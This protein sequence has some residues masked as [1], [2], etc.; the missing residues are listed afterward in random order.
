MCKNNSTD[1]LM[2]KLAKR[3]PFINER[4]NLYESKHLDISISSVV[5]FDPVIFSRIFWSSVVTGAPV[6]IPS[7]L[8]RPLQAARASGSD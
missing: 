5:N 8:W 1:F 4:T 7:I 2:L 6:D 3:G